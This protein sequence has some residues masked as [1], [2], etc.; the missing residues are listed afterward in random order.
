MIGHGW[1]ENAPGKSVW[2]E[3]ERIYH[4]RSVNEG[5]SGLVQLVITSGQALQAGREDGFVDP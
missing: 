3:K 5:A 4:E 1:T 2:S